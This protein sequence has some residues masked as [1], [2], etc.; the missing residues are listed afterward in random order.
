MGG[1]CCAAATGGSIR[2][3]LLA[4]TAR[5]HPA[6]A[7][8]TTR[9]FVPADGGYTHIRSV[10]DNSNL[11]IDSNMRPP[12]SDEYSIGVDREV[13]RGLSMAVAYVRKQGADFI[14]WT[15]IGGR[16][17]RSSERWPMAARCRPLCSSRP[18][19]DQRFFLTNPPGYF[20]RYNGLV[21]AIE[22]RRTHGW[23]AFGSYTYSKSVGLQA[24]SGATA[25]APQSSTVA[26]PNGPFGRDPNDLTNA[27]GR[28]PNHRPHIFRAMASVDVPKTGFVL[29]ANFQH[30]S[31]K[32]WAAATLLDLRQNS[33]QRVLLEPRGSRRL[34]S[35]SL[36]DLR[37]STGVLVRRN[38][39]RSN[40]CSM[41]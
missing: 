32:P 38:G 1:R 19:T 9:D 33:Q 27:T 34:S 24:S 40:C 18:T 21:A 7:P 17:D 2:A 12:Q 36:L 31:G 10:V 39:P 8:V 28:L 37:L 25:A 4:S 41:C 26:L 23:Q 13:T 11:Q 35:Q 6:V 29:A 14:A 16:Y 22:K 15:D 3:S 20:M 30:F 5:F